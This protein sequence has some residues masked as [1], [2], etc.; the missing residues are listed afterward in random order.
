MHWTLT[1]RRFRFLRTKALSLTLLVALP[2]LAVP[3]GAVAG[4]GSDPLQPEK[5]RVGNTDLFYQ[6]PRGYHGVVYFFHGGGGGAAIWLQRPEAKNLLREA[7]KHKM[8]IVVPESVDRVNRSWS[9]PSNFGVDPQSADR[10]HLE[11]IRRMLIEKG[12]LKK[13]DEQFGIE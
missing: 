6:F 4:S 8:A 7:L 10:D 5:M 11:E 3:T 9:R 2:L 13:N 1:A 12:V